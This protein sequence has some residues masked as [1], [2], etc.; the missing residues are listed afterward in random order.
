MELILLVLS[1]Q[2]NTEREWKDLLVRDVWGDNVRDMCMEECSS[3]HSVLRLA[4]ELLC[5]YWSDDY[6]FI[7]VTIFS[8]SDVILVIVQQ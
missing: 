7:S 2:Y 5:S 4:A 8:S 3:L 1:T 6:S